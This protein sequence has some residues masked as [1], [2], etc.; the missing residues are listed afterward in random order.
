MDMNLI[1]TL[2]TVAV[3]LLSA[4]II[5]LITAVI[6]VLVKIKQLTKNLNVVLANNAKAPEWLAP[7]KVFQTAFNIFRK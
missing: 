2:L 1:V 7:A 4:V 3:I 5:G 6:V